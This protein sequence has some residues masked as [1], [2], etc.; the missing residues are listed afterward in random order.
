MAPDKIQIYVNRVNENLESKRARLDEML[1]RYNNLTN[2]TDT[3]LRISNSNQRNSVYN[4][5]GIPDKLKEAIGSRNFQGMHQDEFLDLYK[6]VVYGI[7]GQEIPII[8]TPKRTLLVPSGKRGIPSSISLETAVKAGHTQAYLL[9]KAREYQLSRNQLNELINL[10]TEYKTDF[11]TLLN[12]IGERATI[13]EIQMLLEA[14]LM[15]YGYSGYIRE[16]DGRKGKVQE[17]KFVGENIPMKSLLDYH[18]EVYQRFFSS[19]DLSPESFANNIIDVV[20]QV[21]EESPE[22]KQFINSSLNKAVNLARRNPIIESWDLLIEGLDGAFR[23]IRRG[24]LT[25][26]K[27][28]RHFV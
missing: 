13:Q 20:D 4:T 14:R 18:R 17:R 7:D 2:P 10:K 3:E 22:D 27:V 24:E 12:L 8:E 28:G 21:S 11:P 5:A 25:E 19:N 15:L 9:K 1:Q 26:R 23:F 6:Q 16:P